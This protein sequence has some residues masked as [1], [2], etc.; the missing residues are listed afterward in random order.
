MYTLSVLFYVKVLTDKRTNGQTDR[1][2]AK[3]NVHGAGRLAVDQK[4][5]SVLVHL[6]K[7]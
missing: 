1:H 7:L 2:R 4:Q 6:N 3:H 5:P